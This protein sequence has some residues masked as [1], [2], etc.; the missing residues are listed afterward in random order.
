MPGSFREVG[1]EP[2][3]VAALLDEV[4]F[5][6]CRAREFLVQPVQVRMAADGAVELEPV[7]RQAQRRQ[8]GFD[9]L[10]DAQPLH[11][12]HDFFAVQEPGQVHL[13]QRGGGL[14]ASGETQA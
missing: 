7:G 4:E 3:R 10:L 9:Q 2:V 6:A 1:G 14:R 11:L 5:G 13:R 12:D 8:V